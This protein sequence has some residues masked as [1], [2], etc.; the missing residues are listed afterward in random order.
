M[1]ILLVMAGYLVRAYGRI[2]NNL[3]DRRFKRFLSSVVDAFPFYINISLLPKKQQNVRR[4][5]FDGCG[6]AIVIQGPLVIKDDFTLE[7][8]RRYRIAA[9]GAKIIVSTWIGENE[10]AIEKLEMAGAL[11]ICSEKPVHGGAANINFQLVST[12]AGIRKATEAGVDYVLKTRTDCRLYAANILGY[13]KGLIEIFPSPEGLSSKGRLVALDYSTRLYVPGHVS[14]ILMF[15]YLEDMRNYWSAPLSNLP[16]KG[17]AKHNLLGDIWSE[18]TPEVYLGKCYAARYLRIR[19]ISSIEGWWACLRN[20]FIVVDRSAVGFY[21]SKYMLANESAVEGDVDA[22]ALAVVSH[23]DWVCLNSLDIE[24]LP[25]PVNVKNLS[26][27][28][29]GD[30]VNWER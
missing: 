12:A 11:V 23:R 9:P 19:D 29:A 7:T 17:R 30:I 10:V 26:T 21:W 8:V 22:R 14:D 27:R 1:Q 20:H 13:L 6:V 24:S 25:I 15:G 5:F 28:N 2:A 4:P 16:G 3:V 18:I